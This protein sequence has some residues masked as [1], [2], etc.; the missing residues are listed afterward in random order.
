MGSRSQQWIRLSILTIVL[1]VILIPSIVEDLGSRSTLSITPGDR[2]RR[3]SAHVVVVTV[4]SH[5]P[6]MMPLH[7]SSVRK[8]LQH[9]FTYIAVANSKLEPTNSLIQ[10]TATNLSVLSLLHEDTAQYA[11]ESHAN[12]LQ[13]ALKL[14]LLNYQ[15]VC[16]GSNDPG[17]DAS[18]QAILRPTD[19]LFVLDSDMFLVSNLHIHDELKGKHII[20]SLQSR[21]GKT[22]KVYYLWPNFTILYF[23]DLPAADAL[24][25]FHQLDFHGS[26]KGCAFDGAEMDTGGCTAPFLHAHMTRLG[27]VSFVNG[28]SASSDPLDRL[29]CGFL[30]M[31]TKLPRDPQCSQPFILESEA[32]S[33]ADCPSASLREANKS[34]HTAIPTDNH[35][36]VCP[37]CSNGKIFHMG[38]A[39]SNWRGC[40]EEVL[41]GM[42][43]RFFD[44]L[45]TIIAIDWER[46]NS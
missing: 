30:D 42:R 33:M 31:E 17:C 10:R 26:E 4:W 16:T 46:L 1:S 38:S 19:I 35:T 27:V 20:T 37:H 5:Y 29:T 2:K 9:D 39:G 13:D 18:V 15:N 34:R 36:S 22:Q 6:E 25:F 23:G 28:C 41:A 24:D 8:F 14:L 44:Y 43:A 11:G 32:H 21:S 7:V 45:E 40:P 3:H 12:A